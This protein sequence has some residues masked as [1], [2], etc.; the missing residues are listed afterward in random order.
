MQDSSTQ[1]MNRSYRSRAGTRRGR[2]EEGGSGSLSPRLLL[3]APLRDPLWGPG[4]GGSTGRAGVSQRSPASPGLPRGGRPARRCPSPRHRPG[5][6]QRETEGPPRPTKAHCDPAAPPAPH[7]RPG[8]PRAHR[9]ARLR[10]AAPARPRPPA[11]VPRPPLPAAPAASTAHARTTAP[12]GPRAGGLPLPAAP[13]PEDYR[14]Q[15]P[16]RGRPPLRRLPP[17]PS[18]SRVSVLPGCRRRPGPASAS[19]AG[20]WT[21]TPAPPRSPRR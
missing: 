16:P 6:A 21:P 17:V 5:P 20:T 9:S 7:S 11:A 4:R 3:Q 1:K 12:G 18:G 8:A 10:A 19:R 15:Q 2:R 14:S 13:A